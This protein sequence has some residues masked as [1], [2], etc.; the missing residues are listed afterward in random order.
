MAHITAQ[1][2]ISANDLCSAAPFMKATVCIVLLWKCISNGE[3][4]NVIL[5]LTCC[6][7]QSTVAQ[8]NKLV[9]E[10]KTP[11]P[12]TLD[13]DQHRSVVTLREPRPT[14]A[15]HHTDWLDHQKY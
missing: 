9:L 1:K 5:L 8:K 6:H 4:S 10:F 11:K 3:E 13:K 7:D 15:D 2:I 14:K 12:G